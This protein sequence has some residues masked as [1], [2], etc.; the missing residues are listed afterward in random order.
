MEAQP[1]QIP[2][3]VSLPFAV[4]RFLGDEVAHSGNCDGIF[5]ANKN[6]SGC[7]GNTMMG[8]QHC[9]MLKL[10]TT[11]STTA[12]RLTSVRMV[13]YPIKSSKMTHVAPTMRVFESVWWMCLEATVRP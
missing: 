8:I 6:N 9:Q 12:I 5:L 10:L 11:N 13:E 4:L 1:Q 7:L 2:S 3:E